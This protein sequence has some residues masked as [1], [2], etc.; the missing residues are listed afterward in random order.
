MRNVIN[1]D[2]L[3]AF[4][5][6]LLQTSKDA[7][8]AQQQFLRQQGNALKRKTK[9]VMRLKGIK[10]HTGNYE[11]GIK[12]GKVWKTPTGALAIRVY[13][14]APHAHLIEEGHKLVKKGEFL[15]YV[16]GRM[17]FADALDA[18]EP[19][20]QRAAAQAVDEMIK[21]I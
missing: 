9:A 12:R 11:R 2:E 8:K 10:R 16:H 18:F 4:T 7:K 17:V 1:L 20:F 21:K 14:N 13:S 5:D 3:D 6:V 19:A 15:R